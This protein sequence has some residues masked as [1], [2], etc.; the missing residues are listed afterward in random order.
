MYIYI[1]Y[2]CVYDTHV[3]NYTIQIRRASGPWRVRSLARTHFL[4]CLFTPL[5]PQWTS[6]FQSTHTDDGYGLRWATLKITD[7]TGRL[8]PERPDQ[9]SAMIEFQTEI[10]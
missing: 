4:P 10:S 8:A 2:I 5:P 7:F 1:L 9:I 6:G 3:Q